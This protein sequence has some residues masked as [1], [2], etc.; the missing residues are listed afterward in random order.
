MKVLKQGSTWY[1]SEM[2][3]FVHCDL[4]NINAVQIQYLQYKLK[5]IEK[6][7]YL[8]RVVKNSLIQH[9]N[10]SIFFKSYKRYDHSI[11]KIMFH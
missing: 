10:T 8:F 6:K 3:N 2:W 1:I 5:L 4:Y 11:I 7:I 9:D